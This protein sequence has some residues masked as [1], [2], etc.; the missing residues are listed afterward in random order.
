MHHQCRCGGALS[1]RIRINGKRYRRAPRQIL[2]MHFF[3]EV[4]GGKDQLKRDINGKE[5]ALAARDC[6]VRASEAPCKFFEMSTRK[7]ED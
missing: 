1:N 7:G 2:I 4:D 6:N 5:T 3:N